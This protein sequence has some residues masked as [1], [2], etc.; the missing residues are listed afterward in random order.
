[1]SGSVAEIYDLVT[2]VMSDLIWPLDVAKL[3]R[4]YR[5]LTEVNLDGREKSGGLGCDG[6]FASFVL[7]SSTS[8]PTAV[9]LQ[10]R[11]KESAG[12]VNSSCLEILAFHVYLQMKKRDRIPSIHGSVAVF[13]ECLKFQFY[14]NYS[15]Q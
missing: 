12:I 8:E 7:N 3:I 14:S 1:M 10:R 6:S 15:S 13:S 2:D 4:S 5:R 9:Q 11:L